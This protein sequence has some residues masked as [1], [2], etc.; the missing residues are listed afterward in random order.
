MIFKSLRIKKLGVYNVHKTK[1]IF[2]TPKSAI[3]SPFLA[4]IKLSLKVTV[5]SKI[6][7]P[8]YY[9]LKDI[10]HKMELNE[11]L[12]FVEINPRENIMDNLPA[13]AVNLFSNDQ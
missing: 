2:I 13:R 7:H 3:F 5:P 4:L 6:E 9:S 12:R 10:E 11:F 1:P 8:K